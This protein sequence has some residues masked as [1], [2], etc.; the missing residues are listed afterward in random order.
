VKVW[1]LGSGREIR[2]YGND[3]GIAESVAVRPDGRA[4]LCGNVNSSLTLREFD[5]A[6]EYEDFQ[7]KVEAAQRALQSNPR[8][9]AAF[10]VLGEWWAFRGVDDWAVDS[11]EKGRAGGAAV[12]NL[13]LGRC[14]WNLKRFA[15]AEREFTAALSEAD[16]PRERFYLRQ[17]IEAIDAEAYAPS[18][19][20]RPA[21][22]NP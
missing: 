22:T 19:T 14:Y 1:D 10:A 17:C 21:S 6:P 16:D 12:S 13:M 8:D 11:L 2:A 15:D 3:G 20:T 5:R 9:A 4:I 7:T 18:L